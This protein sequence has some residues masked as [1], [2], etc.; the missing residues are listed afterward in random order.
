MSV[1][2]SKPTVGASTNTWGTEANAVFDA[3]NAA[4]YFKVKTADETV[5]ASS[6]LQDDDHLAGLVLPTGSFVVEARYFVSGTAGGDIKVA[7]QFSG[8]A[9]TAVRGGI[10]PTIQTTSV[11]ETTAANT[12]GVNRAAAAGNTAATI[13]SST[14]YGVDGTNWSFI[15]ESGYLVVTVSGTFKVQWAQVT[16]TGSTIMRAGSRLLIR[17]VA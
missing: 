15:M 10:G 9:T 1:P 14:Q 3:L 16:A 12:V 6:T 7:W 4:D 17:Q 2:I 13:T 5:S 11:I 8:T